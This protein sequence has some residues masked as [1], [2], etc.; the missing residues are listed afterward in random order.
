MLA[1]VAICYNATKMNADFKYKSSVPVQDGVYLLVIF[2]HILYWRVIF[3]SQKIK[4]RDFL[5]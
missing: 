5:V 4:F 3:S 2:G 1:I